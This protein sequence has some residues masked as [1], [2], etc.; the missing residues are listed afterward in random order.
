[1]GE[2]LMFDFWGEVPS[3]LPLWKQTPRLSLGRV[4]GAR[5]LFPTQLQPAA[6]EKDLPSSP[7]G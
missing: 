7:M 4:S 6:L 2:A 1:M 3:S 5:T